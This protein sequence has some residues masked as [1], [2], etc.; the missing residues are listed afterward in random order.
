MLHKGLILIAASLT[1]S[2]AVAQ[3]QAP[4]G[5]Q[6]QQQQQ[7]SPEQ[8]QR[9]QQQEQMER[10]A[11]QRQQRSR[12]QQLWDMSV[13]GNVMLASGGTPP[14]PVRIKYVCGTRAS[15]T[16]SDSKGR[17]TVF[18]Q[19]EYGFQD[20]SLAGSYK[21]R[22]A[23][24][25][26]MIQA[27]A[28]GFRSSTITDGGT[29]ILTPLG[30]AEGSVISVTS[31]AAP[32]KAKALFFKAV[33]ELGKG[34]SANLD[35]AMKDLQKAIDEYPEYAAAWARLGQVKAESGDADGAIVALEK[36]VQLD[37]RYLLPYDALV[38]LY[39]G[40]GDWDHATELT[41]FVLGINPADT[42]MRWYQAV[43]S[44]ETG[45]D[46][47]AMSLIG[48][49]VKDPEAAK[50][51]PQTQRIMGL[52]YAKRGEYAEAAA[53]YKRYVQWDPDGQA[54]AAVKKQLNEW[55]ALGVI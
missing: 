46:D 42:A 30:D 44:Y 54:V 13:S 52:I 4:A 40:K 24:G 36:S 10:E 35:K 41:K 48:E 29:I 49:V 38:R 28:S 2:L 26:C 18:V 8:Q 34:P 7:P 50:Q 27:V 55:E 16:L 14:E 39:M 12:Q 23:G 9:Q 25:S 22:A 21:N 1:V 45:H 15:E 3:A 31:L 43:C 17:F 19:Q 11:Q 37:E 5:G 20:A 6:Q 33:Q 51:F 47:E 53:A 32:K